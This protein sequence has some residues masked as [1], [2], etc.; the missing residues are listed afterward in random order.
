MKQ[1]IELNVESRETGRANS[2]ALRVGKMVPAVIYGSVEPINVSIHENDVVK[3]KSRAFEN[4][5]LNLKSTNV[6]KANGIV[7]LFKEVTVNPL[8]RRPVHVDLFSL[9][10]TKEV[11]VAV[12]IKIE[13]KAI[14][15]AEGGMLSI[16]S[17]TVE[18][19]CLPTA[20]PDFI[21]VDVTNLNV[22]DAIHVSDITLSAGLKFISRPEL[23][24]AACTEIEDE[25]IAAPVAAAVAAPAAGAKAPAG[26]AAAPAAA[27]G[28]AAPK[29]P[30]GK[31]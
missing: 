17:R 23:T 1:R 14:G 31:K 3:Y 13:G 9:D 19:E 28:K 22:G 8:T 5:L 27:A 18:I 6:T 26:K 7:A 12:E 15:L 4:A 2:R 16:V 10:L 20:I 30:A 11:R 21:T 24:I 29:A 25:V